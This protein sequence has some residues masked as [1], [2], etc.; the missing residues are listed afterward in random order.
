MA[1]VDGFWSSDTRLATLSSASKGFD[2][3]MKV[4]YDEDC[5]CEETAVSYY[6]D[7]GLTENITF[8]GDSPAEKRESAFKFKRRDMHF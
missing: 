3:D 5:D 7:A 6:D 1:D 8:E 4:I 2:M